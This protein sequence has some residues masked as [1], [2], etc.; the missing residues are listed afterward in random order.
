MN[1]PALVYSPFN[2]LVTG[3]MAKTINAGAY[4]K[5]I[6]TGQNVS[7]TVDTSAI[8]KPYPQFWSRVDGG[9]LNQHIL[10]PSISSI[11]IPL[12]PPF[13]N[14]PK[15]LLE[16]IV[17]STSETVSRWGP[18]ATGVIF[19]RI[20]LTDNATVQ[21]PVRKPKNILIY[22]DSITEGVR[23][24][25][26]VGIP[27]DTDRNDAVRDY[28]FQL[29]AML[30]AEVGIVAF[31]ASGFTHNGSGKVPILQ[32]SYNQLWAGQPRSF[33]DPAPDLIV[34]NEGTNDGPN[35]TDLF[36]TV[37]KELLVAA[38]K[39]NQLL[40]VPFDGQHQ[41]DI[42]AVVAE[43]DSPNVMVGDTTGFYNGE[44]G[45][46]PFGYAHIGMIAPRVAELC[47]KAFP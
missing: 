9:P 16:I 45:L 34:Y 47:W 31:G 13:S 3:T 32:Q 15:H 17:K 18:Q 25:G 24:M 4:F 14:S 22:G 46:H 8:A 7:V 19:T 6:F 30:P 23:T 40:L 42:Q 27:D 36:V 10:D 2:W 11:T 33:T 5:T 12:G 1:D 44:D 26:Y 35:I 20:V 41:K 28:S 37:V 43:V 21:A 39:A 38:P 29:S